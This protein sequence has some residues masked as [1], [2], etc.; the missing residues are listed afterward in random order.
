MTPS[1]HLPVVAVIPAKNEAARIA[2]TVTA[3]HQ[4]DSVG[5]VVVVDDGSTDD[6][7]AVAR[8]AGALVVR[9]G[10]NRGKAA[11]LT[12]GAEAAATRFP[13]SHLLLFLDA[14]LEQS[15]AELGV[16]LPP[17]ASGEADMSIAVLPPQ[18]APGGGH[19]FVVRLARHGIENLTGWVPTQPLSGMRCLSRTA[20]LASQPF[21][22]G[23][24]AE[25]GLTVDVL[26][27]GL[28]VVE[29][30]CDLHHRVTGSDWPGQIHRAR[31]YRDV[32]LALA[33]R[34]LA[35][36]LAQRRLGPD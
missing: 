30:P 21:A 3:V 33:Q 5:L 22:R 19:G 2:T 29:V 9:H 27:A 15:A 36:A 34:R 11:A 20:Y 7:A 18:R 26:L 14:D 24:G 35:R 6:T 32:A 1:P 13:D 17:V 8:T 23:W 16:L 31:Q 25:V 4:L 28:R 10:A 12:T